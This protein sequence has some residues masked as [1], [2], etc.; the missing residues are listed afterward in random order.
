MKTKYHGVG[1]T[2]L[3]DTDAAVC[4]T[5]DHPDYGRLVDIWVPRSVIHEES[6][7]EI[8]DAADGDELEVFIKAWWFRKNF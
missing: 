3:N 8:D 7:E 2:L 6:L 5:M 1:A 4:M